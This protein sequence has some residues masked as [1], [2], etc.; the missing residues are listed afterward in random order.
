MKIQELFLAAAEPAH[1][2]N[3]RCVYARSLERGIMSD[4]GNYEL[5][6]ILEANEPTIEEMIDARCQQQSVLGVQALFVV[7]VSPRFTVARAQIGGILN[8]GDSASVFNPHDALL[9]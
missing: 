1:I 4:R 3:R 9:E 2:G 7:R 8:E 6:V 5:P